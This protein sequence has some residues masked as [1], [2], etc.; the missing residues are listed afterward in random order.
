MRIAGVASQL[1]NRLPVTQQDAFRE[2]QLEVQRQRDAVNRLAGDSFE[3]RQERLHMRPVEASFE[4]VR[5]RLL[6]ADGSDDISDL[7]H[8]NQQAIQA[9]VANRPSPEE[10]L[11]VQLAGIDVFA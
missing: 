8:R 9:F 6:Q 4:T 3:Q 11:G 5:T 1:A 10:R 2:R 7:P